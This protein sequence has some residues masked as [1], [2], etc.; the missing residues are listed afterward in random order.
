EVEWPLF[1]GDQLRQRLERITDA[2][3]NTPRQPGAQHIVACDLRVRRVRLEADDVSIG[4]HGA[5]QP[6]RAIARQRTNLENPFRSVRS[7][8]QM[9]QL[10]VRGRDTDR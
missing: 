5:R 9:Q 4:Q 2:N 1:F 10:S 8:N 6:Y 7:R 3:L